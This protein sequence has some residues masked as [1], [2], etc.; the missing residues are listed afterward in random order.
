MFLALNSS[1]RKGH[2]DGSRGTDEHA[3]QV[4]QDGSDLLAVGLFGIDGSLKRLQRISDVI[5]QATQDSLAR[6]ISAYAEKYRDEGFE[7]HVERT[8]QWRFPHIPKSLHQVLVKTALHRHYRI[9]YERD[10]RDKGAPTLQHMPRGI[11]T[12]PSRTKVEA[13]AQDAGKETQ[14]RDTP[15]AASRPLDAVTVSEPQSGPLTIDED[16]V[17]AKIEEQSS[18]PTESRVRAPIS[19]TGAAFYPPAPVVPEGQETAKCNLCLKEFPAEEFER[20]QWE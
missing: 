20:R 5:L 2:D 16:M 14:N 4:R 10:H 3:G 13:R 15:E 9:L 12:Q 19:E 18:A 6:R 17:K 8:I 7:H 1:L 11:A